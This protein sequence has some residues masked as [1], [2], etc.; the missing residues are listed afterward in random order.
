MQIKI[1]QSP[2]LDGVLESVSERERERRES[3]GG[4]YIEREREGGERER[5]IQQM[6]R[7]SKIWGESCD[8]EL[9][10]KRERVNDGVVEAARTGRRRSFRHGG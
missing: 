2:R 3:S 6:K 5:E 8:A 4:I 1:I 7:G 9:G 10:E